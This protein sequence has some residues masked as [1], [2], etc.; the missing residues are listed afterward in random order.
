ME[1]GGVDRL[2]EE[3]GDVRKCWC[4][5]I[6]IAYRIPL[7]PT[8]WDLDRLDKA[9]DSLPLVLN[10]VVFYR[11]PSTRSCHRK[12]RLATRVRVTL[13]SPT[14]GRGADSFWYHPCTLDHLLLLG[15]GRRSAAILL[16]PTADS[17]PWVSISWAGIAAP[18]EEEKDN[19]PAT[20]RPTWPIG[21]PGIGPVIWPYGSVQ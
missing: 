16:R 3:V 17:R 5:K 7:S 11:P 21:R 9:T 18:E 2:G 10:F 8:A 13:W 20:G 19:N 4:L 1:S 12:H 14:S 15:Q 6:F